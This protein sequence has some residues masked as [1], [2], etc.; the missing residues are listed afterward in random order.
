[1]IATSQ[2]C[3]VPSYIAIANVIQVSFHSVVISYES[4]GPKL[5]SSMSRFLTWATR[6]V[7]VNT[8]MPKIY[9]SL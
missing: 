8:I 1:M 2:F 5:I 6:S 7:V 9:I 4:I 3:Q